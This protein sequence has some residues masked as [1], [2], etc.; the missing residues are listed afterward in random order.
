ML[1]V[2]PI[3]PAGLTPR[4]LDMKSQSVSRFK[5][6]TILFVVGILGC[7]REDTEEERMSLESLETS[8]ASLSLSNGDC[9][10]RLNHWE[11]RPAACILV[12]D[13][14]ALLVEVTYGRSPGWDFPGGYNKGNEPACRTAE[15]ETCEE[16]G[17]A[18]RAIEKITGSVFKCEIVASNA[19]TTPVD[20]GFLAKRW[21]SVQQLDSVNYRG[22]TWGDKRSLLRQVLSSST[23]SSGRLDDCGCQIGVEGW[24]TTRGR[25]HSSSVTDDWEA[26][27]CRT[28]EVD[29]CGC[30]I[31]IEGWST[32]RG[33]CH[34]SSETDGWEAEQC[35]AANNAGFDECGCQI[36]VEGWSTTRGRCHDSSVTDDWEAQQCR[37]R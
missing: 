13:H 21:V 28:A 9:G 15:R 30:R 35:L 4:E 22:G 12:R 14:Q 27:Q 17:Y 18:V 23:G 3:T 8:E 1:T 29:E 6:L 26:E 25:C 7:S 19:C 24:S 33:R 32:T 31:G 34:S 2:R 37:D 5:V 36:G 20:E 16:T 10:S 11:T